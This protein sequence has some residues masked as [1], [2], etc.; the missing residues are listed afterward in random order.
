MGDPNGVGKTTLVKL[1]ARLHEPHTGRI[2]ADGIDITEYDP[3]VWR[4]HLSV[5]FQDFNTYPL[6]VW[7][8]IAFGS[9]GYLEDHDGIVKAAQRAGALETIEGLPLGFETI[10]SKGFTGGSDLSGGQWQR[11]AL[12]RAIFAT[13]H[14][15]D[16]LVLDEPTSWLDVRGLRPNSSNVS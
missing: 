1:L 3:I 5:V 13:H 10:L 14:G 6:S 2:T 12:A 9:P 15:A 8:N 11:I 7:D 4:R 16:V